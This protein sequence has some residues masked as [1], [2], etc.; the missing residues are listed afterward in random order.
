VFSLTL[1][2]VFFAWQDAGAQ[3]SP[4]TSAKPTAQ[5]A[6][7]RDDYRAATVATG[8]AGMLQSAREFAKKYP[9][10]TLRLYL[11]QRALRQ[12]QMENDPDGVRAAITETLAIDPGDPLALVLSA[13][14]AADELPPSGPD[15]D[16]KVSDIKHSAE[17]ALH[18][19]DRGMLPATTAPQE[20]ELYRSTLQHMAY[21]ALGIMKLKT[22]DDAGAEKDLKTAAGFSTARPDASVWYHLA[23]AQDHRKRYTAAINSVEQAMQLASSNPQ[24]QRLAQLEHERLYRLTGRASASA[25]PGSSPPPQ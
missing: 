2:L 19:L 10:S 12:Y 22:G 21:S 24:L 5:S 6:Q 16:R 9:K 7:E 25:E 4:A 14:S 18:N 17:L 11:Y 23:L 20:A 13:T 1:A 3:G 8:G 15:R